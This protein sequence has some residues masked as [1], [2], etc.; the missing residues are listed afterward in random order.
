VRNA[1][2]PSVVNGVLRVRVSDFEFQPVSRIEKHLVVEFLTVGINAGNVV[3]IIFL[4][5]VGHRFA[6]PVDYRSIINETRRLTALG[7]PA[8]NRLHGRIGSKDR[9]SSLRSTAFERRGSGRR[10]DLLDF[11]GAKHP[12]RL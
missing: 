1:F 7:S 9:R 10:R 4:E 3:V 11:L 6:D 5:F 8:L 2:H 12:C